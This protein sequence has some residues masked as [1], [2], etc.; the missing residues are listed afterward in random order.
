MNIPDTARK[1]DAEITAL[2]NA[3]DL[4]YSAD[5]LEDVTDN[6]HRQAIVNRA[7]IDLKQAADRLSLL[8]VKGVDLKR[9]AEAAHEHA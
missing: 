6:A 3:R 1:L 5:R 7:A 8:N 2:L 4:L 9:G